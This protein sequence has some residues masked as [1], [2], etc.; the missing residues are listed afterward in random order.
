MAFQKPSAPS[1]TARSGV[2]SSPRRLMSIRSSRQLALPHSGLEADEF[3]LALGCGADQHQDAFGVLFHARLQVD[4]VRPHVDLT[5]RREVALLP[6]VVI[7][8]PLRR[9]PCDHGRRQ[10]RRVLAQEGGEGLLEVAGRHPR[11]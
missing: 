3:L 8:L 7:R 10:I 4:A 6:G 11:R 5:P 9:Q 1:P 2:I